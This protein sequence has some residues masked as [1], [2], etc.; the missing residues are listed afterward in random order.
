MLSLT[1]AIHAALQNV[2][3][4]VAGK[5][6]QAFVR[7]HRRGDVAKG[8]SRQIAQRTAARASAKVGR[9]LGYHASAAT[10]RRWRA[11]GRAANS[12]TSENRAT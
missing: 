7:A 2:W 3:A 1:L 9:G 10:C 8:R 12:V 5:R 6:K 11:E 4:Q